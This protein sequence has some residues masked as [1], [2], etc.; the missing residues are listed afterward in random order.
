MISEWEER[1]KCNNAGAGKTRIRYHSD[2]RGYFHSETE[3]NFYKIA[4]SPAIQHNVI[5]DLVNKDGGH[6]YT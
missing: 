6:L 1:R 2:P 5:Q 4:T 3:I